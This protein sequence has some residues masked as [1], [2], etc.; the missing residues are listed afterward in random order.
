MECATLGVE[1]EYL[2]V[3]A[4]TLELVPRSHELLGAA[5]PELGDEVTPE[6]NLCQIEVGTPVCNGLDEVELHLTRLRHG[7][8][9]AGEPLGLAAAA[10][11]THPVTSWRHQQI[12]VSNER[13]SRMDDTYQIVARQQVICG[14]HVHV[15]IDDPDLVVAVMNRVRPWM[16]SLLALTANSPFWRGLDSGFDSYRLQVW[17]RWPMSGMQPELANRQEFDDL[18]ETLE[19]ADAIEDSS[20]LY[21]YARPSAHYPTLEFRIADVCLDV[22]DA[23]AL[24]GLARNLAWTCAAQER[25]GLPM[26]TPPAEVM[27]AAA[28]RAARYGLSDSLISCETS[29]PQPAADVIG[30]LLSFIRD[31]LDHH[32]DTERVTSSVKQILARGN[33]ATRQR[34][35]AEAG[36]DL[37]DVVRGILRDSVPPA[38]G[39]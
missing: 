4:E 28:W 29:T 19:A 34:R 27:E 7:L 20:F 18:V 24:A 5:R 23:V 15:G 12:D 36:G 21:W 6:L 37:R 11:A 30:E 9:A 1:E 26:V 14:C 35:M 2:V 39:A 33:G 13:Y 8:A 3:D 22:E 31:G 16:P 38:V 10:T 17:Q 25:A 32:G